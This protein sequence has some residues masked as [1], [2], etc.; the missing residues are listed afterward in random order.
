MIRVMSLLNTQRCAREGV[1]DQVRP[2]CDATYGPVPVPHPVR[3]TPV[4]SLPK[5]PTASILPR[6]G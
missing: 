1:E 3:N 5:C 4:S 2:L 6:R